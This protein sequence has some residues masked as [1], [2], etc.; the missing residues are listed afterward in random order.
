MPGLSLGCGAPFNYLLLSYQIGLG[1]TSHLCS[2]SEQV[3]R[4]NMGQ[5]P[6]PIGRWGQWYSSPHLL[7]IREHKQRCRGCNTVS[8]S[9]SLCHAGQL[10]LGQHFA[11]FLVLQAVARPWLAQHWALTQLS[12]GRGTGVHL[13]SLGPWSMDGEDLPQNP[14][15]KL[16][17]R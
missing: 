13:Y 14:F 12:A 17:G 11:I 7:T 6:F 9:S 15:P 5:E 8:V 2:V 10:F 1:L 4:D 16:V 3:S